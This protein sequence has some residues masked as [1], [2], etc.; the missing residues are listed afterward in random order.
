MNSLR[1]ST[2]FYSLMGISSLLIALIPREYIY[3]TQEVYPSIWGILKCLFNWIG[4]KLAAY[5]ISKLWLERG[6]KIITLKIFAVCLWNTSFIPDHH[7]IHVSL[8]RGL[9]CCWFWNI[10]HE[11][12]LYGLYWLLNSDPKPACFLPV[13]LLSKQ[14]SSLQK[15]WSLSPATHID[16]ES[17]QLQLAL[18]KHEKAL[19]S[20]CFLLMSLVVF[21]G[22]ITLVK[23]SLYSF[24]SLLLGFWKKK[25]LVMLFL[26]WVGH[27]N[28]I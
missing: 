4:I 20:A 17:E 18:A 24:F 12:L 27:G 16:Y 13:M 6:S 19:Y 28:K 3:S 23:L 14:K 5:I 22:L 26:G 21:W 2:K 11:S 9:Y 1:A 25:L 15:L 8:G 10:L 7:V